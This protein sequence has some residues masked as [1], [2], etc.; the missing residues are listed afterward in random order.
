MKRILTTFKEKWP[1]YLL[2]ILVIT[3]GILGAFALNSWNE[4]QKDRKLEA[5]YL[6]RLYDDLEEEASYIESFIKYNRKVQ[7]FAKESIQ[8]FE[9]ETIAFNNSQQSLIALYQAS[10]FNDARTTASTYKELNSSGQI[11]LISNN[12]LRSSIISFYELDWTNSVIF[13]IP[14][15]YR[16][17]LRS[18]MPSEI[19]DRIRSNCRDVY[20]K[21]K[22]SIAVEIPD[23][24][25]ISIPQNQAQEALVGL[26]KDTLLQESLNFLIGNLDSKLAYMTYIDQQLAGMKAELEKAML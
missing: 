11:N 1:E 26:L 3:I 5:V 17:R 23:S 7:Y 20:V 18:L 19:Q 16:T 12:D 13:D 4:N 6:K 25:E 24:C 21:T 2:E 14:N 10:Q 15:N 22:K 9:N 8:Y